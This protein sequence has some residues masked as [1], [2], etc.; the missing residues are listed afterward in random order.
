MVKTQ[1]RKAIE[2]IPALQSLLK[3]GRSAIRTTFVHTENAMWQF[4]RHCSGLSKRFSEPVFVKV[5]AND[6]LTGDPCSDI[7]MSDKRWRGLL[8]EP[9][10]YCFERL[11]A[12]FPDQNRFVLE[13]IA[14]GTG[15]AELPFFCVDSSAREMFPELPDWFDQ[16]GS[17]DRHHILKHL[18]GV[19]EPYVLEIPVAVSTLT[20]ILERNRLRDVHLLHID[21]EGHDYEALKTLD[22]SKYRPV[23]IF[24]EHKHLSAQDKKDMAALLVSQ[25]YSLRDCGGDY[26]ALNQARYD[27]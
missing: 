22:F 18:G 26:F 20:E 24:I 9:V 25:G 4:R 7:L 12:N 21:T 5:V 11:K 8:I 10:P 13:Q 6:G 17:F 16:L 27:G 19:L 14:I 23:I 3:A 15:G 1:F 2:A